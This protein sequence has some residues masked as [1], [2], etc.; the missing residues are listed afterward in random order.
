MTLA[1]QTTHRFPFL[2]SIIPLV[3]LVTPQSSRLTLTPA[4]T[5]V[6]VARS[7]AI[8]DAPDVTFARHAAV[9]QRATVMEGIRVAFLA[10]PTGCKPL[11]R[12]LA[13]ILAANRM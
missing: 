13:A 11:A 9:V 6:R 1:W 5:V 12:A 3:A 2:Q 4:L 10:S 7:V 8:D